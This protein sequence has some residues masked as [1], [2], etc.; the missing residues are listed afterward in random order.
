MQGLTTCL[1]R[2]C[3]SSQNFNPRAPCEVRR[4]RAPVSPYRLEFQSTDPLRDPTVCCIAADKAYSSFQSTDPLRGPTCAY[5]M[6][7]G[8]KYHISI[9]GPLARSDTVLI[10][11]MSAA[12]FQSTGPM[13]GPTTLEKDATDCM[14]FQSTGLHETRLHTPLGG[15]WGI[16]SIHGST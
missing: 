6:N 3:R 2:Q 7:S 4:S 10:A 1:Q 16:I 12:I 8:K 13:R 15:H 11:R 9:H 14:Q 5:N